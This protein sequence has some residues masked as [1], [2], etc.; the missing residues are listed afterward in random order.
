MKMKKKFAPISRKFKKI[1][2]VA[3]ITLA[4]EKLALVEALEV[5]YL[6]GAILLEIY[7]K[8]PH[9]KTFPVQCI[10]N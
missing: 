3:K 1:Q 8:E 4:V 9:S 10:H 5:Y 2:R 7:K 6:I